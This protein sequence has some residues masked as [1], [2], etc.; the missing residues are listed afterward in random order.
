MTPTSTAQHPVILE[1]K[2]IDKRFSGVHA[3]KGVQL[4]LRAGEIKQVDW[5]V[6]G[7]SVSVQRTVYKDGAVY[8]TD[9]INTTYV[10]WPDGYNYGPGTDIGDR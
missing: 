7:A 10:P 4:E 1:M 6:N 8:F 3:L 9:T 5:A 2:G